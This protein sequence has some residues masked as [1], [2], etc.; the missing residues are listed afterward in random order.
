MSCVL[1][2]VDTGSLNSSRPW[3][4]TDV[5]PAG[6]WEPWGQMKETS[7]YTTALADVQ[8]PASISV[9]ASISITCMQTF[10]RGTQT[11]ANEGKKI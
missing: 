3:P 11:L 7:N 9:P 1:S 5:L 10:S 6:G 8:C 4:A 2:L